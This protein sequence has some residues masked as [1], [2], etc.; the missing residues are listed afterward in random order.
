MFQIHNVYAY[1]TRAYLLIHII[2]KSLDMILVGNLHWAYALTNGVYRWRLECVA[3]W[4][5][6]EILTDV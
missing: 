3:M 2:Y 1:E 6:M 5:S 4:L